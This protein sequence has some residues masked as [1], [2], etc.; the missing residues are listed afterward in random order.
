MY[1]S[2][3]LFQ[4]NRFQYKLLLNHLFF[5]TFDKNTILSYIIIFYNSKINV[6]YA[7]DVMKYKIPIET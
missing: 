5:C 4:Q 3:I 2:L 6:E 1:L 7:M